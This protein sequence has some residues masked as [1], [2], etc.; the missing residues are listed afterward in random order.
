MQP[1]PYVIRAN[2]TPLIHF[3]CAGKAERSNEHHVRVNTTKRMQPATESP[4][5]T[6]DMV[7]QERYN[8]QSAKVLYR[9]IYLPA[10]GQKRSP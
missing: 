9:E 6:C 2:P 8:C 5:S 7:R 10:A 1:A 3:A 4:R